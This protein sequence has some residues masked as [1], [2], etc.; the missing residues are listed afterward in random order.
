MSASG[1]R[2]WA[3]KIYRIALLDTLDIFLISV[4][5]GLL[6][7]WRLLTGSTH[8]HRDERRVNDSIKGGSVYARK[9]NIGLTHSQFESKRLHI[10]NQPCQAAL[11]LRDRAFLAGEAPPLPLP[12]CDRKE[13]CHC[14]YSAHNDRRGGRERRYPAEDIIASDQLM[15]PDSAIITEDRREKKERRARRKARKLE[16]IS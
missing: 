6:I 5:I 14:K 11:R 9:Q 16:G 3:F 10:C 8:Q 2:K 7:T 12:E 4:P 15:L 1:S 13:G